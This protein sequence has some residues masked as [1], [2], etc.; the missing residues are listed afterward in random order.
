M[1]AAR[2][3]N[4]NLI[5]NNSGFTLIEIIVVV[6]IIAVMVSAIG[7]SMSNDADRIA[8]WEAKHFQAVVNDAR[9]EAIFTGRDFV[10]MLNKAQDGYGIHTSLDSKKSDVFFAH[11]LKPSVGLSWKVS[12]VVGSSDDESLSDYVILSS[13]GELTPFKAEFKGNKQKFYVFIDENNLVQLSDSN[14]I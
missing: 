13:L 14:S 3:K 5:K 12:K 11:K 8:K 9:D 1:S 6:A 4:L 2:V 7:F 10:L